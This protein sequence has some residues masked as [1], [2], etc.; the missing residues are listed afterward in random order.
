MPQTP[1]ILLPPSE[2]KLTGG[3][4]PRWRTG[5]CAFPQL[6]RHR[7]R[8]MTALR[9]AMAG[10]EIE[11]SKLLGVKGTALASATESDLAVHRSPTM[12]AIDRYTGVLY[13]A[14]DASSLPTRARAR[15]DTDV[16]IFSGLF[17]ALMPGDPIPDY[18]LKMGGMLPEVGNVSL[19]WRTVLSDALSPM[20]TGRALWNLLPKEH[21]NAW[22][23]PTSITTRTMSVKFLDEAR[24]SRGGPRSFT[25]VNHW[26]KLLKGALV[27]FILTTGADEPGALE[28]FDHPEGYRYD[29][30]LTQHDGDRVLIHLVR[31]PR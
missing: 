14:L 2:G 17:G 28:G 15:L 25:T 3:L 20:V 19:L 21:D 22:V 16:V 6:D 10:S 31:P 12:A 23:C 11:R 18:K 30:S 9:T 29:P 27:R 8:I 26:N 4:G 13:D 1:V 5:S 7:R 24:R